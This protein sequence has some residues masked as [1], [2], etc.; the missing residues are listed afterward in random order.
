MTTSIVDS[1]LKQRF[2]RWDVDGNGVLERS[3]FE[4]EAERIASAFGSSTRTE[5]GKP[6]LQAFRG[7]YDYLAQQA[8]SAR[9]SEQQFMQATEKLIFQEGESG[10]NRLLR[11]TV[12][13]IVGLADRN[14]DGKI[15]RDEFS[16]W[17]K[18]V[19]VPESKAKAGF[20]QIDTDGSGELSEEE[21]LTA[22]RKFHFG[23]LDVAL[24]G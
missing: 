6:L 11:P 18:A 8:G 20:D 13:A 10:F 7:L 2:Q 23:E 5:G 19:G 1:R 4:Q 22:V 3:D 15:S 17:L 21:L 24:L 9:I 14:A 12:Q 16:V